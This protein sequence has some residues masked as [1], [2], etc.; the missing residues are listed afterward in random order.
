MH[1]ELLQVDREVGR[2]RAV[3][4]TQGGT[5]AGR[6]AAQTLEGSFSAVSKQLRNRR[7]K[8]EWCDLA[9]GGVSGKVCP[10]SV[11]LKIKE[12]NKK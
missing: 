9:A 7:P 12:A 10:L 2:V 5:E 6:Q 1:F 4:S 8:S 3:Y 11:V